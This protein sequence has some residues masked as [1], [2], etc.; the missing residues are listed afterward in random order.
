M[1]ALWST[2]LRRLEHR[3]APQN[4]DMWLRPIECCAIDGRT[5]RLRAPNP[6]VRFWFESNYLTAVLD[7]LKA[8]TALEYAVEFEPDIDP[9]PHRP[10]EALDS[11]DVPLALPLS[12]EGT[13]PN[14]HGTPGTN[15]HAGNG[16]GPG[17]AGNG[18]TAARA[19]R[20]SG[21]EVLSPDDIT[22]PSA[23]IPSSDSS[24]SAE[25]QPDF[26]RDDPPLVNISLN[27]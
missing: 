26:D 10:P 8:E 24:T 23:S 27:P 12:P 18:R 11:S 16:H 22:S 19:D 9:P 1:I 15:G 2:A 20:S 4:F 25:F 21:D 6:Y 5:I 17:Y 13:R 7:E 14:L 3:I